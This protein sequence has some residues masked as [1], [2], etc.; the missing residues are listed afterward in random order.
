[1]LIQLSTKAKETQRAFF[2][3]VLDFRGGPVVK[4]L[5]SNFGDMGLIPSQGAK[6][7]HAAGQLCLHTTTREAHVPQLEKPLHCDKEPVH[8]SEYPAQLNNNS[9]K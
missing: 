7:P 2:H 6:I 3:L 4:N 8:C 1:M 9:K 5:P